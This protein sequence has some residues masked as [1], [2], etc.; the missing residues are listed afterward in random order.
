MKKPLMIIAQCATILFMVVI[1]SLLIPFWFHRNWRKV[2][3]DLW[4]TFLFDTVPS[5][6]KG[7]YL[8]G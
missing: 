6:I 2:L 8:P 5:C 1:V 4:K 7:M 3:T